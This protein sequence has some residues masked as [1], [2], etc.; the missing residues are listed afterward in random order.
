R[1]CIPSDCACIGGQGQ[2]C[3]NDAINPACT[4]GHVFECNAQTG[5]TCNYG[6]RDSC[7]QCGQLQC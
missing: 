4:N 2:F 1:A 7:V 3:G 6:V 5:K